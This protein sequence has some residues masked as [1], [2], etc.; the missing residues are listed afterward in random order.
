MKHGGPLLGYNNNIPY[1][2]EVYHVQTEDSGTKR[3]HV[4]THLFADGGRIIKTKKTSYAHLLEEDPDDLADRIRALMKEQHKS[5]VISLRDGELDHLIDPD[6]DADPSERVEIV[7]PATTEAARSTA[8]AAKAKSKDPPAKRPSGPGG[9]RPAAG[10]YSYVGEHKSSPAPGSKPGLPPRRMRPTGRPA[11][12]DDAPPAVDDTSTGKRRR[13]LTGSFGR[14]LL[15]GRRLD[16]TIAAF[17][18]K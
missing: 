4:F 18:A 6:G 5:M 9:E 1:Q 11:P 7:D 3:P 12:D 17:L 8:D 10:A 13:P 15:S 2:G 16:E 14:K